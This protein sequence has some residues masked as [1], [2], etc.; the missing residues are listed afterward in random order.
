M[1]ERRRDSVKYRISR[2]VWDG[3]VEG[4]LKNREESFI[5]SNRF[6]VVLKRLNPIFIDS[7]GMYSAVTEYREKERQR[8]DGRNTHRGKGHFLIEIRPRLPIRHPLAPLRWIVG[9]ELIAASGCHRTVKQERLTQCAVRVGFFC[10]KDPRSPCTF[11]RRP[12]TP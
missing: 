10:S 9:F 6:V 7:D 5:R 1:G 11:P 12:G 8:A 3:T 2:T 4:G